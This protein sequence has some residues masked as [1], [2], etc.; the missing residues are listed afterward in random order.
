MNEE[1]FEDAQPFEH[2]GLL[3]RTGPLARPGRAAGF[4]PAVC[5]GRLT[6]TAG[7]KRAARRHRAQPRVGAPLR[8]RLR[9]HHVGVLAELRR[10]TADRAGRGR[11]HQRHAH[12]LDL[13]QRV[14]VH[15]LP[16]RVRG[17]HVA[18]E[19]LVARLHRLR[20][21]VGVVEE[22]QPVVARL[23]REERLQHRDEGL[24]RLGREQPPR[25]VLEPRVRRQLRVVDG[26]QHAMEELR[27]A[28][29][30]EEPLPVGGL[31][32][33]VCRQ[34][35]LRAERARRAVRRA[36]HLVRP[37]AADLQRE[38]ARQ[39]RDL[40]ELPAPPPFARVQR[41]R[42]RRRAHR[43]RAVRRQRQHEVHRVAGVR[44]LR[45]EQ[46]AH[47]GHQ[48][49][50]RRPVH[51]RP[52]LAE[53]RH[54]EVDERAVRRRQRRVVDAQRRRAALRLVDDDHVR[55]GGEQR[56]ARAAAVAR[57]VEHRGA[58]AAVQRLEREARAKRIAAR[59][60][61]LDHVGAVIGEEHRRVRARDAGRRVD[62]AHAVEDAR[63][64][65]VAVVLP[66]QP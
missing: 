20:R 38:R 45:R 49:R 35:A 64:R 40:D 57:E 36:R 43:A 53:R 21:D 34:P 42:H 4:R 54:G 62:D 14:V 9:E 3:A 51:E 2:R 5:S 6:I 65:R 31:V 11:R 28:A 56:E 24:D 16:H 63:P 55:R 47:R 19:V 12:H 32:E 39:L 48:C 66:D 25:R 23:R 15:R 1:R 29:R 50:R 46:P 58:L 27:R 60:L 10:G 41:P 13:A 44:H 22:A 30:E 26:D 52:A 18:R 7:R 59:R 8:R 33:A 17:H 37:H 61:D